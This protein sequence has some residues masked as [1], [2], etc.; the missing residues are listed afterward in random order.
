MGDIQT[1]EFPFYALSTWIQINF[2]CV[3][4]HV[5]FSVQWLYGND[6]KPKP[7]QWHVSKHVMEYV[8]SMVQNLGLMGCD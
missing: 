7:Q 2:V 1:L 8:C 6:S 4:E 5:I 3:S